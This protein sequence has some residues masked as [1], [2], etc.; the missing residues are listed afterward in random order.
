MPAASTM[1]EK[2]DGVVI[3]APNGMR[4]WLAPAAV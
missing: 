3:A 2:G 4:D 1:T